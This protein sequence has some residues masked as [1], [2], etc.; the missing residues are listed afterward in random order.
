MDIGSDITPLSGLVDLVADDIDCGTLSC[1]N[2]LVR[3]NETV[4]GNLTVGNDLIVVGDQI[5]TGDLSVDGDV[6]FKQF[7]NIDRH[8][9][10]SSITLN[11]GAPTGTRSIGVFYNLNGQTATNQRLP[12]IATSALSDELLFSTPNNFPNYGLISMYPK[13]E[14]T[15][16]SRNYVILER[17]NNPSQ[18]VESDFDVKGD[19]LV[20]SADYK[21]YFGATG[22]PGFTYDG[23]GTFNL[24]A[25]SIDQSKWSVSGSAIFPKNSLNITQV[26]IGFTG[27]TDPFNGVHIKSN[28][29]LAGFLAESTTAIFDPKFTLRNSAN[30]R[31]S[32][33]GFLSADNKLVLSVDSGNETVQIEEGRLRVEGLAGGNGV[34]DITAGTKFGEMF[35]DPSLGDLTVSSSNNIKLDNNTIIDGNLTVNG[36]GSIKTINSESIVVRKTGSDNYVKI[37]AGGLG[38]NESGVHLSEDNINFGI[39]MRYVASNDTLRISAVD[40]SNNKTDRIVMSYTGNLGIGSSIFANPQYPLHIAT[41]ETTGIISVSAQF[42]AQLTPDVSGNNRTRKWFGVNT[43]TDNSFL[44]DFYYFSDDGGTNSRLNFIGWAIANRGYSFF[45]NGN[46]T[47]FIPAL[48]GNGNQYVGADNNGTLFKAGT[49]SDRRLKRDICAF[50]CPLK[51]IEKLEWYKFKYLP[52]QKLVDRDLGNGQRYIITDR[53]DIGCDR[54]EVGV[55]AQ[56]LIENELEDCV[57]L[58]ISK[59]GKKYYTLDDKR[60]QWYF[61]RT[62]A[63]LIKWNR[64][65]EDEIKQLKETVS[66]L[67]LQ[68]QNLI[69]QLQSKS[70]I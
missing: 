16:T 5:F 65:Q 21:S 28:S 59:L 60:L 2:L 47:F 32:S 9:N 51:K 36:S 25:S 35:V 24:D 38:S 19:L 66:E 20:N 70:I 10:Q 67:Q 54:Q 1:D 55:M 57:K 46:G 26:A 18:S 15:P 27:A 45:S 6:R 44:T 49:V 29:G 48:G 4:V 41:S 69:L 58:E 68:L 17:P 30:S 7:V 22:F 12:L 13:V 33:I 40:N 53:P 50:D 42:A 11:Y 3:Q 56:D 14:T 8:N 63:S 23:T 34:F 64:R 61:N 31:S 62:T 43:N 39:A 52:C 37:E